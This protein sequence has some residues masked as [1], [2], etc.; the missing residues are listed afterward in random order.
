[1]NQV[2][3]DIPTESVPVVS[4]P[5]P[6]LILPSLP[7]PPF[8]PRLFHEI[9]SAVHLHLQPDSHMP[10]FRIILYTSWV[11]GPKV[12]LPQPS[13]GKP[14]A[15]SVHVLGQPTPCPTL[16]CPALPTSL[17]ASLTWVPYAHERGERARSM[18]M[19]YNLPDW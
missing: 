7:P 10:V 18:R 1:M 15:K 14:R 6:T 9:I 4:R 3:N 5:N 13:T 12:L 2:E 11:K 17:G 16:P 8:S 19:L